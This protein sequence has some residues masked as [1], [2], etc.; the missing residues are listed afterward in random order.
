M[1]KNLIILLY[2]LALA[3]LVISYFLQDPVYQPHRDEFLYL[4]EGQH[5]AWG[6]MEI[7]PLL[8]VFAGWTQRLGGSMFWIK[9]W[10]A[11]FGSLTYLLVGRIV[12]S[13]GGRAF[14]LFLSWL[15]FVIGVYMRLFF[16]FQPNF[17][18][19]FFWTAMGYCVI[20]Y[21]QSGGIH[22]LYLLG[23]SIGLGLMSKYS[24]AFYT[25]SLFAGLAISR[26]RAIFRNPHFYY[27]LLIAGLIFLPNLLWQYRHH[28]PVTLHMHELQTQ[29]LQYV[30]PSDFIMSQLLMNLP[31]L[32]IWIGGLFFVWLAPAGK[33]FRALGWAYAAVILL[34]IVLHGKDYYALGAYPVLFAFG[35]CYI[36]QLTTGRRKWIRYGLTTVSLTIGIWALPLVMPI[37]KPEKLAHYYHWSGLDGGR[38]FKWE[39][40]AFHPLP[41]DFSDMIGWREMAMKAGAIYRHLQPGKR[42][43]VFIFCPDYCSA[44][45]LNYFRREA[46]LPEVY[47]T[48]ASFL[49]WMPERF[50]YRYCLRVDNDYPEAKERV[51]KQFG[52]V[53]V[54]DSLVM[55]YFRE[56]G[57]RFYLFEDAHDSLRAVAEQ[58]IG[59]EKGRWS[60]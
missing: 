59:K 19:V 22:Y 21:I 29:Q 24:V 37:W 12:L 28:F 54:M 2:V 14:A 34:L 48:N 9:L 15:P 4:A 47:S 16:L 60:E 43:S 53:T 44:G 35:G 40:R 3:R 7:P 49:L 13:L 55:P 20:R 32:Y 45:A 31:C 52:K 1:R 25:L 30:Q 6:Y 51:F 26:H 5:P 42:D 17:L 33:T 36:E 27:M 11:L 38:G 18:E 23:F 41:Q 56:S 10:P 39:D 58:V 50:P 8:S 46:G 57:M